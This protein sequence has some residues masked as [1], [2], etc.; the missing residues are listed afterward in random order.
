MGARERVVGSAR[1]WVAG[2][3]LATLAT[4]TLVRPE[5]P[6]AARSR[7]PDRDPSPPSAGAG[8]VAHTNASRDAVGSAGP[9]LPEPASAA[10]TRSMLGPGTADASQEERAHVVRCRVVDRAGAGIAGAR[11][12]IGV[13]GS[14]PLRASTDAGGFA[15]LRSPALP[16]SVI[17]QKEGLVSHARPLSPRELET[18]AGAGEAELILRLVPGGT[19][20]A[21]V[22]DDTGAR[23]AIHM[24]VA[25]LVRPAGVDDE[26]PPGILRNASAVTDAQGVAR[27]ADLQPGPWEVRCPDWKDCLSC[28]RTTVTVVEGEDVLVPLTVERLPP[29]EVASGTIELPGDTRFE[30]GRVEGFALQVPGSRSTILLYEPDEYFVRGRPGATIP[31]QLVERDSSTPLSEPFLLRVGSR[32]HHAPEW[33]SAG[34][35]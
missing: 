5:G 24:V 32:A 23:R 31:V 19:I 10:P 12:R 8:S 34:D 18:L 6:D 11:I 35:R 27:L 15:E 30:E 20:L 17:V 21:E 16:V 14:A 7:A 9:E 1:W 26:R 4:W 13:Q 3:V 25:A 29:S 33:L 28:E 22:R 2:L